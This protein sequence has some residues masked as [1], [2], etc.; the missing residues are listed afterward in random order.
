MTFPL[1]L[2]YKITVEIDYSIFTAQY[3]Q[4]KVRK[5]IGEHLSYPYK[6][7]LELITVTSIREGSVIIEGEVDMT[8]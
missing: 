6:Y 3:D 7:S 8:E 2:K 4:E 5:V 1:V